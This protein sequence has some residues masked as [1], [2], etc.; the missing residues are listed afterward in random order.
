M[1]RQAKVFSV[2]ALTDVVVASG[3][4]GVVATLNGVSSQQRDAVVR[5]SGVVVGLGVAATVDMVLRV[6]RDSLTGAI[7][8]ELALSRLPG[9]VEATAAILVQETRVEPSNR[10]YVLTVQPGAG[11]VT[12]ETAT[13]LALVDK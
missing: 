8:G 9:A 7:V 1:A 2:Q 5:L 4:E 11:Q 12:A 6:R 13:L 10:T 3:V